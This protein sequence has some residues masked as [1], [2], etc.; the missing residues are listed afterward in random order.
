MKSK[1]NVILTI[2]EAVGGLLT[3]A[4]SVGGLFVKD[5]EPQCPLI[6]YHDTEDK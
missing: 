1:G 3:I 4:A 2:I 6:S 5:D